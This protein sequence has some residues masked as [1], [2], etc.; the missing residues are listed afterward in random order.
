MTDL[1]DAILDALK[2]SSSQKPVQKKKLELVAGFERAT[3][4]QLHEALD[5]LY[6]GRAI[7][8]CSG[9]KDGQSYT[10]YWLTGIVLPR[11]Y[12]AFRIR[13]Q[14]PAPP[15]SAPASPTAAVLQQ[16]PSIHDKDHPMEKLTG[17]TP[18][19]IAAITA[20]PGINFADL[21]GA[22]QK[23]L[24]ALTE[25]KLK[26]NLYQMA[27]AGKIASQ[28]EGADRTYHLPGAKAE[29]APAKAAA[30]KKSAKAQ[31]P[32]NP[33]ASAA[34]D[35]ELQI[36]LREDGHLLIAAGAVSLALN[37]HHI[38]RVANFITR[39]GLA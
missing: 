22:V 38:Q 17:V 35:P 6:Q 34:P 5:A 3:A 39:H 31:R 2:G 14:H 24:P 10:D 36:A 30:P 32:R 26:D 27:N 20:A 23:R 33:A 21:Y 13:P 29:P 4:A 25:K 11:D 15:R 9:V 12:G 8:T 28:G 7:N 1:R 19:V 16:I 18:A 37:E